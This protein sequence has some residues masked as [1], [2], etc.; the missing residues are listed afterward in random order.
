MPRKPTG[1]PPGRPKTTP[2]LPD[3]TVVADDGVQIRSVGEAQRYTEEFVAANTRMYLDRLHRIALGP[4]L[5][6]ARL[7]IQQLQDRALG[8]VG[9]PAQDTGL[10]KIEGILKAVAEIAHGVRDPIG[11]PTIVDISGTVQQSEGS[12]GALHSAGPLR[13][14]PADAEGTGSGPAADPAAD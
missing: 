14:P 7:A 8:K 4:D 10:E 11:A 9:V 6:E 3:E 2:V 1:R 5:K 12:H 13:L